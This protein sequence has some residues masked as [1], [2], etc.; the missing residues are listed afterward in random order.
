MK[1]KEVEVRTWVH[2]MRKIKAFCVIVE[3]LVG[4]FVS[5]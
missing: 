3:F 5:L 4:G 2:F 1:E